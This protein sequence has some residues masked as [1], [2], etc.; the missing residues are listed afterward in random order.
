MSVMEGVRVV[1][2]AQWVMVP[3]AAAILAA[4]GADV[5]RVEHPK[6]ADPLRG[7][8]PTLGVDTSFDFYVENNNH[9]KRSVGLDLATAEGRDVLL[10]LISDADVFVTSFLEPA[11]ERLGITHEELQAVNPRLIY[12]RSHGQGARGPDAHAPGYD[13]ISYW[14]R[15]S[16]GYMATS[17]GMPPSRAP[18]NGFGDVQGGLALAA[19]IAAALFRR[20][21]TGEAPVVDASLLAVGMWDMYES[22]QIADVYG[23]DPRTFY[24][25]QSAMVNP[26]VLT[27]QTADQRHVALCMMQ[28][29]VHWPGFCRA[30]EWPDLVEDPRFDSLA[31]R[32]SN[33]DELQGL[34]SEHFGK[35]T[36]AEIADALSANG[37]GFAAHTSP[38]EVPADP[39]VRAN[40]FLASHPSHPDR[41]VVANPV[42]FDGQPAP[43]RSAAPEPGQHTEEVLLELGYTWDEIGTLKEGD[44]VT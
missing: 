17:P 26:L 24:G 44:V 8:L 39:Q 5:V 18:A 29:D 13:P 43:V 3:S 23:V 14:A 10:R 31:A 9:S 19:G 40:G 28:S 36:L 20:S 32:A 41:F 7:V 11:R 42:Q 25:P 12:A 16:A 27:Y 4:W 30:L 1:E 2:V 22:I 37:C 38:F 33:A 15:S 21:T 35:R 34:I 6:W